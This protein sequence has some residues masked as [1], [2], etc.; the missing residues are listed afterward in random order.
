M[1]MRACG[2]A[3]IKDGCLDTI[4]DLCWLLVP[5]P[6]DYVSNESQHGD[7]SACTYVWLFVGSTT[8]TGNRATNT[9]DQE[10]CGKCR[11]SAESKDGKRRKP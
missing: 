10:T 11:L 9:H 3:Q 1:R 2:P 8:N 6:N 5:S 4:D 7:Q